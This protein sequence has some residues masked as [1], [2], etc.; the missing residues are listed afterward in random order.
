MTEKRIGSRTDKQV[1]PMLKRHQWESLNN[2][3]LDH[4]GAFL[5]KN[6]L[7][8]K[9]SLLVLNQ[10]GDVIMNSNSE[11][12]SLDFANMYFGLAMLNYQH[13][14]FDEAVR[15]T[16]QSLRIRRLTLGTSHKDLLNDYDVLVNSY[17]ECDDLERAE[18][19]ALTWQRIAEDQ[20]GKKTCI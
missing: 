15:F 6:K 9:E 19:A 2:I 4:F 12:T 13:K 20:L 8:D 1:P 17:W 16:E 10:R 11:E 14:L 5:L 18:D 7:I 3:I